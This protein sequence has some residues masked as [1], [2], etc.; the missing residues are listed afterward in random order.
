MS[1]L[2]SP[3][4]ADSAPPSPRRWV[5]VSLRMLVLLLV[6]VTLWMVA[7]GYR[8]QGAIRSLEAVGGKVGTNPIGPAWLRRRLGD[9][10]MSRF[11]DA[12]VVSL[13]DKR[14]TD[15]DLVHLRTLNT[16]LQISLDNSSITD[17]G[18]LHLQGLPRL[19]LLS[20]ENTCVGDRGV[21]YLAGIPNLCHLYLGGTAVTDES[22]RLLTRVRW[23]QSVSL[24]GTRITDAGLAHLRGM[25]YLHSISL[26]NTLVTDAGV[27]ELQRAIPRLKIER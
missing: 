19:E 15:G 5:P 26:R 21:E 8:R 9:E 23:L 3:D 6:I 17:A 25:P 11:E 27:A 12:L 20:L 24:D 7:L 16:F 2:T 10:C 22:L 14:V 4:C 13:W 1:V 18:L